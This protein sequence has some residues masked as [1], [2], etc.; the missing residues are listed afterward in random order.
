MEQTEKK[1]MLHRLETI[2]SKLNGMV[3]TKKLYKD[4]K[5]GKKVFVM[6]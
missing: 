6:R 4:T 5:G 1:E 2:F 3:K